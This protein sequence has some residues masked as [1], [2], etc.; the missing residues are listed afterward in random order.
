MKTIIA[1]YSIGTVTTK[2]IELY[3]R[4]RVLQS[5]GLTIEAIFRRGLEELEQDSVKNMAQNN[6]S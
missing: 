1:R 6:T 5:N 4:T 3:K 2:D